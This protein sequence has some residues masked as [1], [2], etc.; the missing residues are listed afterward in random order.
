MDKR[1]YNAY[2]EEIAYQK[3]M[4]QNVQRWLSLSFLISTI[5]VLIAYMY[6]AAS[7]VIAIIGYLLVFVGV[8]STLTFGLG[9]YRGRKNVNKV[10]D[11]FENRVHLSNTPH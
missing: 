4:L 9:F 5:G 1:L 6:A 11:E 7:L 8:L 3:H 10:I 2:M